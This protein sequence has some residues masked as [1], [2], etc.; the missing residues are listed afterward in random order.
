MRQIPGG[1]R[2]EILR[3]GRAF[4]VPET[5]NIDT[6]FLP[7]IELADGSRKPLLASSQGLGRAG[8]GLDFDF[9]GRIFDAR[10][11]AGRG[12]KVRAAVAGSHRGIRQQQRMLAELMGA[13]QAREAEAPKFLPRPRSE[14]RW[15]F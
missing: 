1:W 3:E 4:A 12:G 9:R 14:R 15:K 8:G 2:A 10:R 6:A 11:R 5:G 13:G 7:T